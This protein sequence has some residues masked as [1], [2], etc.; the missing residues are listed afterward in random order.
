[1]AYNID[2]TMAFIEDTIN[3]EIVYEGP[4]FKIRK[5]RV[6]TVAGESVRDVLEHN[7][8]VVMIAKT[9][10]GKILM[11]KQFRKPL[12]KVI[13]ELPAGKLEA[14]EDPLEAAK[15]ELAEE[16]GYRAQSVEYL[17]TYTPTC[18]YSNEYLH[19][20]FCKDLVPGEK[21]LDD[22]E[23]IDVIEY[24]TEELMSMIMSGEIMD[25]KTIIG[26]L[27]AKEKDLL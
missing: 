20:Y 7:G 23:A 15:R 19:I 14:G 22:T 18:G 1:M 26:I 11:E 3:S 13:L 12:E 10:D 17:M 21:N 5:H 25:G 9:D 27:Y 2:M 24:S 16:T 4:I 8:G 6:N